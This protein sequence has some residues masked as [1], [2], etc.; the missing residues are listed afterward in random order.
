MKRSLLAL[1]A[2]LLLL[3]AACGDTGVAEDNVP[4]VPGTSATTGTPATG[5]PTTGEPTSGAP[6]TSAPAAPTV[7]E[8][9]PPPSDY[10]AIE[11]IDLAGG[12]VNLASLAP[13]Q[14]PVLLWFWA[15][16]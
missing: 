9:P 12:N 5:A 3:A 2:V 1:G 13:S 10:P 15:P 6:T 16:H 4:F 7:D 8:R 11:V 14:N